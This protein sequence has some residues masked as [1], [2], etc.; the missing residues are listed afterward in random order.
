MCDNFD[1]YKYFDLVFIQFFVFVLCVDAAA[2]Q[3]AVGVSVT[4]HHSTCAM[5]DDAT[6]RQLVLNFQRIEAVASHA[7]NVTHTHSSSPSPMTKC[8]KYST[9]NL[10]KYRI[11]SEWPMGCIVRGLRARQEQEEE[12]LEEELMVG[13]ANQAKVEMVFSVW[14]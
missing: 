7:P 10:F 5:I 6:Q 1:F 2:W 4:K 13:G 14:D 8:H 12:E 11:K 3:A 9:S